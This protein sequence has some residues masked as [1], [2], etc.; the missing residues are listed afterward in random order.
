MTRS[1]LLLIG[2]SVVLGAAAPGTLPPVPTFPLQADE[3]VT[4]RIQGSAFEV[5]KRETGKP[6][7]F[8]RETGARFSLSVT[9]N[10]PLLM[11]ENGYRDSLLFNVRPIPGGASERSCVAP[12]AVKFQTLSSSVRRIEISDPSL[13]PPGPRSCSIP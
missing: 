8:L 2:L 7:K 6:A 10:I 13:A 5:V 12:G 11:V 9:N 3:S 4:V 1:A